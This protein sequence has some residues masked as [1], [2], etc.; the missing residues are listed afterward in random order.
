MYT[1]PDFVQKPG[2]QAYAAYLDA[3]VD[4]IPT[5]IADI[6]TTHGGGTAPATAPAA[7]SAP[8]T[9]QPKPAATAAKKTYK[10]GEAGPAGGF[11]FYDKGNDEGGW[12]YL[13]A[14]P[15]STE[16]KGV[17]AVNGGGVSGTKIEPGTGKQNTKLIVD[18][19]L[20]TG[21]NMP[22]ARYCDRL[23]YGGC[24]DW[25]LPSMRELGLMFLN[26]K[27]AGIGG[28]SGDWY[29]SSSES[30]DANGVWIQRFSDGFQFGRGY[31]WE[32]ASKGKTH[33]VRA[34][35]QF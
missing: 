9:A 33:S 8:A 17:W 32:D 14:A 3:L 28:F 11:V 1:Y 18:F 30:G 31:N 13:E 15:A 35:R 2:A 26:L 25:Y 19:T 10:I 22:A 24:D 5:M 34:I 20:A 23:S 29:W 12:R 27:D 6:Q 4:S 7:S 16:F 21:Q